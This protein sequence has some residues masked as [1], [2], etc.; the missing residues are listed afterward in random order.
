MLWQFTVSKIEGHG[1]SKVH[2]KGSS[3]EELKLG[4]IICFSETLHLVL[5][6]KEMRIQLGFLLQY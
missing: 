2:T 6:L 4:T 3:A 1:N 5:I